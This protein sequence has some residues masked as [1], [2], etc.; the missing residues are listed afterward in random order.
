MNIK[1]HMGKENQMFRQYY[2]MSR[3]PFDKAIATKEAYLTND[4]KEMRGRLEYLQKYPGIAVFTANSGY[5]KTFALRCFAEQLNPN[6]TKFYYIC[7][8][9]VTTTEFYRQLCTVLGLET[10]FNKSTMFQ[11]L[12]DFFENMSKNKHIH[13]VLCL[14]EAQYLKNDILRDLKMLCN[15]EMDSKNYFSLILLGQPTLLHILN[16]QPHEALKQRVVINYAFTG[17]TESEVIA[18]I[19]NRI[20]LVGGSETIFDDNAMIAAT[21]SCGGSLRKLNQILTKAL[22]I[23]SQNQKTSIDSDIILS[24]VNDME[25]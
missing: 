23:G 8:S 11:S 5:G 13:C 19:K 15:F 9:T 2:G 21:S 24:A 18:Y 16:R 7:L 25:L 4:I 22:M 10:C 20:N 6:I 14:D 12:Q 3:N 1:L 17:V